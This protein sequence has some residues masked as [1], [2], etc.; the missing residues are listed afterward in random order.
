MRHFLLFLVFSFLNYLAKSQVN[1]ELTYL[2]GT[3]DKP[4]IKSNKIDTI[5]VEIHIAG[6]KLTRQLSFDTVG[7]LV[8]I[9]TFNKKGQKVNEYYSRFNRFG[10]KIYDKQI[11]F[12]NKP[13]DSIFF[14]RVYNE[15]KQ[16][17]ES[18]QELG[19]SRE[20]FYN[21]NG[22]VEK[23]IS[24]NNDGDSTSTFHLYDTNGNEIELI[25]IQNGSKRVTKNVYDNLGRLIEFQEYFYE[26]SD[27]IGKL[28]LHKRL[29]YAT[30]GKVS[31]I[32]YIGGYFDLEKDTQ[33]YKYDQDDN[34]IVYNEGKEKK[35]FT[36]D[37]KGYLIKKEA[38][39]LGGFANSVETYSYI[40]RK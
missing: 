18:S 4:F 29:T 30:N 2:L 37:A 31:K 12:E 40:F 19:Y 27:T 39:L 3:Y 36:Y 23:T 13:S 9:A 21:K 22:K 26:P 5:K 25:W 1:D 15:T 16:I 28:F 38:P 35:Y 17:K 20:Y 24:A 8:Y 7:N 11:D 14:D 10:D 33:E 6:D 32:E 34:L